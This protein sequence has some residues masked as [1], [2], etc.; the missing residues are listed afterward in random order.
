MKT[1]NTNSNEFNNEEL[2]LKI[3]FNILLEIKI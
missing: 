2:D 1:T 3:L